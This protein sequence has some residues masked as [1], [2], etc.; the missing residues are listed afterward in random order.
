MTS[1]RHN[2]A[3]FFLAGIYCSLSSP[4]LVWVSRQSSQKHGHS[5]P[6]SRFLAKN[7]NYDVLTSWRHNVATFFSGSNSA[8]GYNPCL[9]WVWRQSSQKHGCGG[10]NSKKNQNSKKVFAN[11]SRTA[12]RIFNREIALERSWCVLQ[13]YPLS[14]F[15]SELK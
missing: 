9:V 3:T 15:W 4:C 7:R 6:K 12:G 11:I 2:V 8:T 14:E 5:S 1:W 10:P 13:V